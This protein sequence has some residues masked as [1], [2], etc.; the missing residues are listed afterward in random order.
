MLEEL[1]VRNP[2][3]R[4]FVK[5][6]IYIDLFRG[7]IFDNEYDYRA[8]LNAGTVLRSDLVE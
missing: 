4:M 6:P 1:K 3:H 7:S 5:E 8:S 2:D